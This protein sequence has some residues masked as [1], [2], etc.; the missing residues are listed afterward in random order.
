MRYSD[1]PPEQSSR[2][3]GRALLPQG[4][5][6]VRVQGMVDTIFGRATGGAAAHPYRSR[7]FAQPG[8]AAAEPR[9]CDGIGK[10]I[11]LC[12]DETSRTSQTNIITEENAVPKGAA[13]F[14][15]E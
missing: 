11:A 15:V 13:F 9:A 10:P 4:R 14:M 8:S 7:A 5:E 2:S 1:A 12:V 3:A 6:R